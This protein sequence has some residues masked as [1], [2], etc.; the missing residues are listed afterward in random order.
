MGIERDSEP[1]RLFNLIAGDGRP[2]FDR[3]PVF[4]GP[5]GVFHVNNKPGLR[6]FFADTL[7]CP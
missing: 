7:F 1:N 5:V 2:D 6:A 3:L 4:A